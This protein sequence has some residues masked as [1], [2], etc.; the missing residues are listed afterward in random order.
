MRAQPADEVQHIGVGPHPGREASEIRERLNRVFVSARRSYE[1]IDAIRVRPIGLDG[2][3][4]ES[5][6]GNQPPRDEG[7][8]SVELVRPVRRFADQH[9]T[10][11]TDPFEQRIVLCRVALQWPGTVAHDAR[12]VRLARP[13]VL[14]QAG[15]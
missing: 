10:R 14:L 2:D 1:P 8:L 3:R 11:I 15:R 9:D 7:T 12:R 4:S 6:F 13:L 5:L